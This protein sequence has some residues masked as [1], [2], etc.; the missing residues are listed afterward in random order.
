MKRSFFLAAGGFDPDFAFTYEDLPLAWGL[1]QRGMQLLYE[2]RAVVEHLHRVDWAAVT[3]HYERLAVAERLMVT[4]HEAFRP[5]C[6]D[7]MSA[8]WREPRASRLWTVAVDWVPRRATPLRRRMER[9][10]DRHYR[11]R[12]AL[13]FLSA[14]E[15]SAPQEATRLSSST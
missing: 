10:A 2:P 9:R 12:L 5:S 4:K 8:A 11:Q 13:S 3:R 15:G 14:W 6:F 1:A 7:Q